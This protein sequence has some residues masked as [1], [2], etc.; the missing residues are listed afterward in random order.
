MRTVILSI[1]VTLDGMI[2]GSNGDLEWMRIDD[3]LWE[4]INKTLGTV[5]T[6]LFGRVAYQGFAE[7]W[8]AA[9][10]N[11]SSPPHE[12]SFA[13]WIDKTPKVVF[14]RTL[15]RVEWKNSR[16]AKGDIAGEIAELKR[17]PGKD[18]LMFGG[19]SIASAFMKAGLIDVY[20]V[21][22]YPVVLGDGKPLFKGPMDRI[23]LR[24]E[25]EKT[26]ASGAVGL[27]YQKA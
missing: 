10:K 16:L 23:G 7:Y 1:N 21:T 5:D 17:Q 4:D 24:L 13:H 22:V 18:I 26:F 19:G 9:A 11:P 8:P 15:E 25:S 3:E 20:R 12:V 2:E 6:A 14:S 27:R